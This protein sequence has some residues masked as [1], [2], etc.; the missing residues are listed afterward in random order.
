M[1]QEM[2]SARLDIL[3][4]SAYCFAT[5]G[6]EATSI[7]DI[8][9]H[10]GATKGKIY[11]HFRSKGEL[12][13]AVRKHSV[14]LTLDHVS[15]LYRAGGA[16]IAQ[17]HAMSRAHVEAMINKLDYHRVVVETLRSNGGRSTTAYERDLLDELR[18]LQETYENQFRDVLVRGMADGSMRA[19]NVSVA[20]HT[21]LMLLNAPVHWYSPRDSDTDTD[22]AA[23][24]QQIADMATGAIRA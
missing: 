9:R 17:F 2:T 15:P 11:H 10:L 22:R 12:L 7:D 3:N 6:A 14:Q 18:L 21:V 8:A 1:T 20:L 19:Q 24:A 4:A 5:H 16:P 23:I 13:T